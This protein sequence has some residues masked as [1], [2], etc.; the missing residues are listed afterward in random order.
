[1]P[2]QR[3]R[4]SAQPSSASSAHLPFRWDRVNSAVLIFLEQV[5]DLLRMNYSPSTALHIPWQRRVD[6]NDLRQ[7]AI[8]LGVALRRCGSDEAREVGKQ[9]LDRVRAIP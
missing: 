9:V 6:D 4:P 5:M 1:M 3:W 7:I 8:N 2:F